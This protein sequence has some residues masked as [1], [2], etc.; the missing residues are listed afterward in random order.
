MDVRR[1]MQIVADEVDAIGAAPKNCGHRSIR[2]GDR[3]THDGTLGC[4]SLRVNASNREHRL[5]SDTGTRL[6]EPPRVVL[7]IFA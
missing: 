3:D 5:I 4:A 7:K 6:N 1:L 2:I